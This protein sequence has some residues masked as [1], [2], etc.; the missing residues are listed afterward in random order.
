MSSEEH[1]AEA[2]LASGID[3]Y[4]RHHFDEA[5]EHFEKAVAIAP[6]SLDAHLALG[7]TRLTLYQ[8]RPSPASKYLFETRDFDEQKLTAYRETEKTILAEQTLTNWPLAESSLKRAYQLDPRNELVVEYLCV[9]Y[10]SWKDPSDEDGNRLDDAKQWFERLAEL[11][12]KHT[13]ANFYVGMI[14]SMKARKLL[15]NFGRLPSVPEPDLPS[16]RVIVEPL[17]EEASR[18]LTRAQAVS[19]DQTAAAFSLDEVASMRVYLDDPEKAA[20]DLRDKFNKAFREHSEKNA[21]QQ[22]GESAAARD[23]ITFDLRPEALAE[24]EARKFPPNP[25]LISVV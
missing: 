7:A 19:G 22:D 21:S 1:D 11:N 5:A 14:L 6:N 8:R 20:Q 4:Q 3:A 15:P 17:L 12:P 25:W 2:R 10:F 24:I 23:S 16:R 18:H 13:H 9:L